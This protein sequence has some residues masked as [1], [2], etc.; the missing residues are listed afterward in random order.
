[1]HGGYGNDTL[2]APFANY[3]Y[4]YGGDGHDTIE[5]GKLFLTSTIEGGNGDDTITVIGARNQGIF[6][7]AGDD[8]IIADTLPRRV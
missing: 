3:A 5:G 1:M 8:V 4:I 2:R 7:G 6:G